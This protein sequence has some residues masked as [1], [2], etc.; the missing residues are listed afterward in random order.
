M[1]TEDH[2]RIRRIFSP[3][4]S[5]RAL[6]QQEPLFRRHVDLL[7]AKLY[8]VGDQPVDMVKMFTFT[9]FDTMGDLTFGQPLGLL[10]DT[11]FSPW[12]Q[13]VFDSVR[14]LPFIQMIEYYPILKWIFSWLEP[15]SVKKM[16]TSHFRHTAD[17]VDMRLQRGS[18]E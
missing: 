18:S 9:T 1:G 3:A 14:V 15:E 2:S 16:R 17:R 4:F 6:K 7:T 13:A 5:N 10:K 12:V 11:Q 8:Q